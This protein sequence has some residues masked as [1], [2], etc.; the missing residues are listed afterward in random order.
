MSLQND[1]T[2]WAAIVAVAVLIVVFTDVS[3]IVAVSIKK[4][5]GKHDVTCATF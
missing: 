1:G 2:N 4:D 3:V 5:Q